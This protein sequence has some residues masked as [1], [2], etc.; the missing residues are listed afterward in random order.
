MANLE[1]QNPQDQQGIL[2]VADAGTVPDDPASNYSIVLT[3]NGPSSKVDTI[4]VTLQ[5]ISWRKTLTY[6]G[7]NV[8]SVST[9]VKL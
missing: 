3:R 9:W 5:G 8:T 6:T 7:S 1:H 2:R 4:T